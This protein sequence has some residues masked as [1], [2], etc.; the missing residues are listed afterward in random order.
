MTSYSDIIKK[1]Q[2]R[3]AKFSTNA[4]RDMRVLLGHLTEKTPE[5]YFMHPDTV[6]SKDVESQ[7]EKCIDRLCQNEPLSKIM[8]KREFYGRIFTV[9]KDTLD[10]RQDTETLID[11]ALKYKKTL[12]KPLSILDLGT[13]TGCMVLT[14][15]AE[16]SLATGMGVDIS[17]KALD[18]AYNNA[19]A[20]HLEDRVTFKHSNWFETIMDDEMF[21]LIVSN[22]PYIANHEILDPNVYN[23]DP[24]SALF[25][26][27]E[28]LDAYEVIAKDI[29]K[30]LLPQGKLLIEFGHGQEKA[31][32]HIFESS[33]LK[34]IE[35]FH[36]LSGI[37]RCAIFA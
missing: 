24:H 22:P 36:D 12:P 33:G 7:L 4:H 8:G 19:K 10:P 37:I 9:T 16:I 5:F 11:A 25:A 23:F 15:L 14:L 3:L 13:G 18:V 26:G 27:S 21:A 6:I 17:K 32:I 30:H 28:G 29:K 31:V 2:E 35:S 20:L 1:H 34:H